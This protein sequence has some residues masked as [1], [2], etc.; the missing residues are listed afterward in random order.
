MNISDV[1]SSQ[2]L[3]LVDGSS[4]LYRAFHALPAL[5]TSDGQHTGAIHGVLNM[6]RRLQTE[7]A[8]ARFGVIFDPRGPTTRDGWYD[9][10]KAHRPSMPEELASQVGPLFE[11]IDA[12]GIPRFSVDGI[13]ADDVIGTLA[14][15]GAE[16]GY[17]VIISTGDKDFA[18]LVSE[19]ITLV[20]TMDNTRLDIAGVEA[21]FGVP[22]ERIVD[23]LTLM[24]DAVDNVPGI[25][26]VGPKTAV[27]WLKAHGS[28]EGIVE[29]ATTISGAVGESLRQHLDQIP[30]SKKLVTIMTDLALPFDLDALVSRTPDTDIL[31]GLY[32]RFELNT[33]LRSLGAS[34]GVASDCLLY[35]S[36]SP[37]DRQKS[38]MPSSA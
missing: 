1:P 21:R 27:K 37:R 4:Y 7:L 36:P 10:Y 11:L 28:L 19:D 23:Y 33:L 13:E 25:P 15:R 32:Q 24:G 31:R 16:A 35:T 29:S 2:T 18:Q 14:R 8:P 12:Q 38:R 3:V 30:L 26:K 17:R 22:P 5:V 20:N 34:S 6:L 9:Q